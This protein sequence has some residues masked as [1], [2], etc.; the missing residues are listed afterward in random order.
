MADALPDELVRIIEFLNEQM[1]PAE[2]IGVEVP[3]YVGADG[4]RVLVPRVVGRTSAAKA[5][6]NASG[7]PTWSEESFMAA[8]AE[9]CTAAEVGFL[10]RLF[11]HVSDLGHR[12][13]WGKGA[14]PGVSGWYDVAGTAIP[15]FTANLGLSG[16]EA[17]PYLY[18]YAPNISQQLRA[19]AMTAFVDR[20][21]VI[22]TYKIRF[23]KAAS[24]GY[25]SKYPSAPIA[26]VIGQEAG[27]EAVFGALKLLLNAEGFEQTLGR[28][29]WGF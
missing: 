4:E 29:V 19:D 27:Q 5:A 26:E 24:T 22:P 11:K 3:Q 10:Q 6:K 16:T 13:S 28:G 14:S 2:V 20:L 7:G 9:H 17:K 1:S 23:G 21:A 8:A 15:V 12:F 18:W 25:E